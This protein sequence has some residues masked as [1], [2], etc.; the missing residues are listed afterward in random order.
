MKY[1]CD[2]GLYYRQGRF[3]RKLPGELDGG[4]SGHGYCE[5]INWIPEPLYLIVKSRAI[6]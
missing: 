1:V 2:R 5:E 4:L 3:S 6:F